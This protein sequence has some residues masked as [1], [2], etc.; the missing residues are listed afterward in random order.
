VR[1]IEAVTARLNQAGPVP[2]LLA[3]GFDAFEVIRV[4]ARGFDS[5]AP[6]LFAAFMSTADAAVDGREAITLAPALSQASSRRSPVITPAANADVH[7]LTGELAALSSLL[8]ARLTGLAAI[9]APADRAA[10]QQAAAAAR[11][12]HHLMTPADDDTNV[13]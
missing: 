10:C 9:A 6:A 3:A 8:A 1:A 2:E 11:R 7:A 5:H 12:I 13:R 4:L